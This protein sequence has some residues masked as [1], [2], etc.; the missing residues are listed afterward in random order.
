METGSPVEITEQE[1]IEMIEELWSELFS[2]KTN[3]DTDNFCTDRSMKRTLEDPNN[4]TPTK[5]SWGGLAGNS[6]IPC[7]R[8]IK[9]GPAMSV[10]RLFLKRDIS[11]KNARK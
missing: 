7:H 8:V 10:F 11:I 5:S 3:T 2:V 9:G 1:A 4:G 6:W